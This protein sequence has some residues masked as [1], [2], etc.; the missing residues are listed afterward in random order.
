M[1]RGTI[2]IWIYIIVCLF[3]LR[4]HVSSIKVKHNR[5]GSS[6]SFSKGI[7]I[8]FMFS[9]VVLTCSWLITCLKFRPHILFKFVNS[10]TAF[11]LLSCRLQK[12]QK[13]S[14][15]MALN[16]TSNCNRLFLLISKVKNSSCQTHLL[17]ITDPFSLHTLENFFFIIVTVV[18]KIYTYLHY[19]S[20][21]LG[22]FL[23]ILFSKNVLN[24]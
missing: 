16:S 8:F 10:T 20:K 5:S 2:V 18:N 3:I 19:R 9:L 14:D 17:S 23:K 15:L 1:K 12:K 24:W 21:V 11:C 13:V 22:L 6:V 7:F 4:F